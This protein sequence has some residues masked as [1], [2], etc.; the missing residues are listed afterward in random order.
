MYTK[1]ANTNTY[2]RTLANL[3]KMRRPEA[4]TYLGLV[5]NDLFDGDIE[6]CSDFLAIESS[7]VQKQLDGDIPVSI[8]VARRLERWMGVDAAVLLSGGKFDRIDLGLLSGTD[9]RTSVEK[10]LKLWL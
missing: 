7:T 2:H 4:R 6:K 9:N 5:I 10:E 1:S 8:Y 3:R